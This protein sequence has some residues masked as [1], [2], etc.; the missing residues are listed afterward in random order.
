MKKVKDYSWSAS[1][2]ESISGDGNIK[3]AQER[4]SQRKKKKSAKEK[5]GEKR[6]HSHKIDRFP[7][8]LRYVRRTRMRV[9]AM[10]P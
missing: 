10:R 6:P 4:N 9:S 1:I 7:V 8:P 5:E 3:D 2:C